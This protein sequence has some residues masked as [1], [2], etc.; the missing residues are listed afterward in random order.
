MN[1]QSADYRELL[2]QV[3]ENR[4]GGIL[5]YQ[6]ENVYETA[7]LN[8]RLQSAARVP[9]L[10]AADLETGLG[11]RFPDT[12]DWPWPMAVAA[13]GDPSLAEREGRI[14]AE[15][16]RAVGVNQVYAPVADVNSDPENPNINVRSYGEDPAEVA[17]FVAAFVRGVQAARRRRDGQAFSGSRR[18]AYRLASVAPGPFRDARRHRAP[19]PRRL[20][21]RRS[22]RACARS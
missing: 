16:A 21:G 7:W 14:V 15:E 6:T 5:W 18:H 1:E 22:P 19:G 4:V 3:R 9:L 13:T 11:M 12:T 17:R 20:S 2:R 10:V 8:A